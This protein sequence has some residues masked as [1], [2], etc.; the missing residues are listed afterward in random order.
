MISRS[1]GPVILADSLSYPV[2]G[3]L[4]PRQSGK[5]TLVK[6]LFSERAYFNLENPDTR[7]YADSDPRGFLAEGGGRMIIDEFQRVPHLLSYIQT[8]VDERKEMAQYVLT[9]SQNFLMMESISQSL[10]GRIALFTLLPLSLPELTG[11]GIPVDSRDALI[12]RGLFPRLYDAGGDA[13]RYYR[14][15]TQTYLERDVRQV[16]NITDLA[17]FEQFLRLCAGRVGQILNLSSFADDL[18]VS[19]NTVRA[20][21]TVLQ[22]SYVV[23]L[24]PPYYR[25]FNK[26][27]IKSPKLYFTDTGLAA[28]L[29][30]IDTPR[31]VPTHYLVGGLFENLVVQEVLKNR[32]NRGVEPGLFFWRDKRGREVDLILEAPDKRVAVEIKSGQTVSSDFFTGLTHY[33]SLDDGCPPE[34]RYLLYGGDL[35]ENRSNARVRGW[36]TL[37]EGEFPLD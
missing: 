21:L 24:L 29:L 2:I 32:T 33:G 31:K 25:N 34:N 30:G 18:G 3:L 6:S 37:G 5:T 35:R 14:N 19:H 27:I 15:Y 10:A 12:Q 4:G 1:I 28:Y 13:Y 11:A 7:E 26:Q 8:I 22:T 23:H 17:L 9:G 20:W 36:K 16:K